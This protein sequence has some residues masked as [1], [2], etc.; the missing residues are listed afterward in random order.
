MI[1][2][3]RY[4]A[5]LLAVM[6]GAVGCQV[7]ELMPEVTGPDDGYMEIEFTAEIPNMNVVTTRAVD[8][9][10]G[11]I[12]SITLFCFDEYNTFI[13]TST[14]TAVNPTN[15][16]SGT[17]TAK[18][19]D[20]IRTAHFVAN[21]NMTNYPEDKFRNMSE[22]GV[23]GVLESSSGKMVYWARFEA[24][25][26]VQKKDENGNPMVD[27]EG[28]PIYCTFAEELKL[29]VDPHTTSNS[30]LSF[31]R[32]H[33]LISIENTKTVGDDRGNLYYFETLGFQLHNYMAFGTVAPFHP[34]LGYDYIWPS[35]DGFVTLPTNRSRVSDATDVRTEA[36]AMSNGTTLF[37][38]FTYECDNPQE[39]PVSVIIYGRNVL[40]RNDDGS[41]ATYDT[42][43]YYRVML[44]DAN[45]NMLKIRRNHQYQIKVGGT[46]RN[47]HDSYAAASAANAAATN[48]IWVSISDKIA[49][50]ANANYTLAVARTSYIVTGALYSETNNTYP[51]NP[52][53]VHYNLTANSSSVAAPAYDDISVSW[54]G[55][56]NVAG[57]IIDKNNHTYPGS[58]TTTNPDFGYVG[59]YFN[60]QIQLNLYPL[61]ADDPTE[62]KK[63]G[64]LLVKYGPLQR[65]IKVITVK[66]QKFEPAWVSTQVYASVDA[67]H[68]NATLMFT[69][70]ETCPKEMFPMKV[71]ISTN[72][73]DIRNAS[74]MALPIV[75]DGDEDYYGAE[76][77]TYGETDGVF[78]PAKGD[79]IGYKY[80][81]EVTGTGMQRVYFSNKLNKNNALQKHG[82]I[83]IEARHF[84]TMYKTMEFSD[85]S[86]SINAPK[87]SSYKDPNSITTGALDESIKFL[88]VPQKINAPV[89]FSLSLYEGY[90][91]NNT[92]KSIVPQTLKA[93]GTSDGS[94]DELLLYSQHLAYNNNDNCNF[95]EARPDFW[96]TNGRLHVVT[97][98]AGGYRT[99]TETVSNGTT[100]TTKDLYLFDFNLTT[101]TAKSDETIRIASNETE[102]SYLFVPT[103]AENPDASAVTYTGRKF[104]SM[105]FE[106]A[107]YD[108]FRFAAQV[109]TEDGEYGE[110]GTVV[111][112]GVEN[113]SIPYNGPGEEEVEVI[114][115]ITSFQAKPWAGANNPIVSVDPFGTE[116][117]VFIEAPMLKLPS[118]EVLAAKGFA[119]NLYPVSGKEGV[120]AYK[121]AATHALEKEASAKYGTDAAIKDLGK[122]GT[123]TYYAAPDQSKDRKV[124]PFVTSNIVNT[125]EIKIY[126][127]TTQVGY[128]PKTFKVTNSPITGT[129]TYDGNEVPKG[130]FI[131]VEK[132]SD[133]TRIA[134][135][136]VTEDGKYEL[137]L[138]KEYEDA[139][140]WD[141][142]KIQIFWE[143]RFSNNTGNL[144]ENDKVTHQLV[145]PITL[146]DLKNNPNIN[147]VHAATGSG[148]ESSGGDTTL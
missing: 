33:A 129:I 1:K 68:A 31:I 9:D 105:T 139:F 45:G 136:L 130:T 113:V 16:T 131:A 132:T 95:L 42:P 84:E 56:N 14:A 2:K 36:T 104:R 87:M 62:Q 21:Q 25:G 106:L 96:T 60:G 8:V 120:F 108:P 121:V 80:V 118:D 23:L 86:Y 114:F 50:V 127:D 91:Y 35:A 81:L 116:F 51:I 71:Y 98:K 111:S 74:G 29:N 22:S 92:R 43:K 82:K 38:E 138:R 101:N 119:G 103:D 3:F 10:G 110:Y 63:E 37:G 24:K 30:N 55:E 137:R 72:D 28:N 41:P 90:S 77:T 102:K 58:Y 144:G 79:K 64:T 88:L 75:K 89:N 70:P 115:D 146:E 83:T 49:E 5:V 128:K 57:N 112:D 145:T 109:N 76:T 134:T 7:N 13:T 97:V 44:Q 52:L 147:L 141:Q 46:L 142:T 99:E 11:G 85:Y 61:N 39:N 100:T 20:N 12:T 107:T 4:V 26:N 15:P 123:T 19:P 65:K 73:F 124:L 53:N 94:A 59:E 78:D 133:H 6:A 47:G 135:L 69:I 32:N 122:T 48:N 126:T 17:F 125:G 34:T 18:V 93:D 27:E 143:P 117:E 67:R 40:T 66:Q 148:G 54:I 140:V